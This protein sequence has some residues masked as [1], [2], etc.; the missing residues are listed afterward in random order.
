M[1]GEGGVGISTSY[2]GL[3]W[4]PVENKTIPVL[5]EWNDAKKLVGF[6][7]KFPDCPKQ[8]QLTSKNLIGIDWE[9]RNIIDR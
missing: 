4:C 6:D 1:K 3:V 2:A 9:E 5:F 7:C 8:C